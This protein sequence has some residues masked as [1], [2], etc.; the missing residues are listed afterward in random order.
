MAFAKQLVAGEFAAAAAAVNPKAKGPLKLIRDDKV[1]DA[2]K[3]KIKTNLTDAKIFPQKKKLPGAT[4]VVLENAGGVKSQ[5]RLL[6]EDG[7]LVI[8]E[9]TLR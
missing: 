3:Q 4:M 2:L 5:F 7:K 1:P 8:V 6:K 9:M